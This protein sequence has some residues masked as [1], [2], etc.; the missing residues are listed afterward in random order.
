MSEKPKKRKSAELFA[1]DYLV[2]QEVHKRI[3]GVDEAGRGPLAGPVV[4]AAVCLDVTKVIDGINDSKKLS[5][6]ARETLYTA[7]TEN[8]LAWAVSIISPQE[9]DKINILQA[10]LKA[11]HESLTK[12]AEKWDYVL[13]DGN[14]FIPGME[15]SAQRTIIEGDAKSASIAAASIIA[16]VTRDRIMIEYHE[17]YPVYEFNENKGYATEFHR[18]MIT[19]HGL[20]EIHRRTFCETFLAYQTRLPL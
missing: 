13:I 5:P 19:E 12:I 3:V 14:Q 15:R 11:M 9:V 1:H 18:N 10:S 6:F 20:C 16:K 8:A 7:I 4:A 2:E 17:K